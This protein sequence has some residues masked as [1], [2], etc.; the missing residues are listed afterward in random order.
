MTRISFRQE[1]LPTYTEPSV[2]QTSHDPP[3]LSVV[4]EVLEGKGGKESTQ[5]RK[6]GLLK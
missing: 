5:T 1:R 2:I 3:Y 6:I 4:L